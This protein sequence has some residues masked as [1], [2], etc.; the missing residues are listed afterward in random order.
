MGEIPGARQ[1][2]DR[3]GQA[4]RAQLTEL[5]A[6]LTP[7]AADDLFMPAEPKVADWREPEGYRYSAI[8]RGTRSADPGSVLGRASELLAAA[9]W[10][11]SGP[12]DSDGRGA[13]VLTGSRDGMTIEIRVWADAP[14]VLYSAHTPAVALY[15]PEPPEAP[16][17]VRTPD[18]VTP[19]Y[20]LC[21]ECDGLGWCPTCGGQGWIT[22]ADGDQQPCPEC[23]RQRV[24]P[25]CRGAGQLYITDLRPEERALYAELRDEPQ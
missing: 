20:V 7:E 21:Y 12:E 17:P 3:L 8:V 13:M 23:L 24:C 5:V 11:V 2:L 4:L 14:G 25:I 18:T 10:R 1:E 16:E 22:D 15:T 19:G 9:A 6:R